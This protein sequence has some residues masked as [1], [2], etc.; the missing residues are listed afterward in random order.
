MHKIASYFFLLLITAFCSVSAEDKNKMLQ[1]L[2][3]IK[4]AFETRYAPY[5]W[6]K[7][8]LGWSL[9]EE[10]LNAKVKILSLNSLSVK[11]YQ[12]ILHSFFISTCDYHV[13]DVY[14]STE[15]AMLPFDVKSAN[16][17]YFIS[18]INV[19]ALTLMI[20]YGHLMG[21]LPQIGD[22]LLQFDSQP[23]STVIENLKFSELGNPT[24]KT[25]QVL[26]E[27]ILTRRM[28][29]MGHK[30]P[31]GDI[32][33]RLKKPIGTIS[34][35]K[36]S[37]IYQPEKITDRIYRNAM[38]AIGK[39][40]MESSTEVN[41]LEL[42]KSLN[43]EPKMMINTL[44]DALQHDN[45]ALMNKLLIQMNPEIQDNEEFEVDGTNVAEI[46]INEMNR[47]QIS[48]GK[49]IWNET[50]RT[51]FRAYIYE[52][53]GTKKRI[54]C[55]RIETY[56]PSADYDAVTQLAIR[57][58]QSIRWFEKNTD[59]LLID[60]VDNPGGYSLYA[61]ALASMM[62]DRPLTLPLNRETITQAEVAAA[63]DQRDAF[64]E[65]ID[66]APESLPFYDQTTLILGYP[67]NKSFMQSS[68][69]RCNHI[70]DQWNKGIS[71]TSGFPMEGI[72]FLTPHP[73][74]S[75]SKP[76]LILVNS[77]DF[78]CGDFF[79]AILQDNKRAVIF[80]EQTAGAGGF[81]IPHSYPN[82]FGLKQFYYTGSIASRMNGVVIENLGVTPD[83]PYSLTERDLLQGYPDYIKAVN[84]ALEKVI[85]GRI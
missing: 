4:S 48:F 56:T 80:G 3:I 66:Q 34:D 38:L 39:R 64:T 2:D 24:S 78:S 52:L 47:E 74:A 35:L 63:F 79:P 5:E 27:M 53:P 1:D 58:A 7:N 31:Q 42:S 68:I 67:C 43:L 29:R 50:Q 40:S 22:E 18:N 37:W 23:T 76:I 59:A 84:K 46:R 10:I 14:Y 71:L 60:Q 55:I 36:I 19:K 20:Q 41:D 11:D 69:D 61:L 25:A 15:L 77:N 75:Y 57:L 28:G 51:P 26:A 49:K 85:K 73:L 33:I 13:S 17:K 12:R 70:I 81:V 82:S 9:E 44:A 45:S 62:T 16:G 6:K 21:D 32:Q 65:V 54:G 8:Y 30:I 72:K 83:I